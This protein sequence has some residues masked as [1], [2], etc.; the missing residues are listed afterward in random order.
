MSIWR[1]HPRSLAVALS[2]SPAHGTEGSWLVPR[3]AVERRVLCRKAL[4]DK[5]N[6][7]ARSN[8]PA[9]STDVR[10]SHLP[11]T[12]EKESGAGATDTARPTSRFLS[13]EAWHYARSWAVLPGGERS[14]GVHPRSGHGYGEVM[15]F[16]DRSRLA[17]TPVRTRPEPALFLFAKQRLGERD[18]GGDEVPPLLVPRAF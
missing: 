18:H 13:P 17:Q 1:R 7:R 9:R 3:R 16:L 2:V 6:Q 14:V 11:N 10:Q 5:Q 8:R 4:R 12:K 15:T